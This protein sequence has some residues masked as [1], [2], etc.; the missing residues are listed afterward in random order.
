MGGMEENTEAYGN[1]HKDTSL[2]R[3]KTF[4]FTLIRLTLHTKRLIIRYGLF[5]CLHIEKNRHL[6]VSSA[7]ELSHE[8]PLNTGRFIQTSGSTRFHSVC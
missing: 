1:P 5:F 8:L 6:N 2:C 7:M 3:V 4:G